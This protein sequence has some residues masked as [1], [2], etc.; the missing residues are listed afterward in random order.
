MTRSAPQNRPARSLQGRQVMFGISTWRL[1]ASSTAALIGRVMLGRKK[2]GRR[3][4]I[5]QK[6]LRAKS[7]AHRTKHAAYPHWLHGQQRGAAIAGSHWLAAAGP[8]KA[9]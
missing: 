5:S 2:Q 8:V 1:R 4:G 3:S 6:G 7:D 9:P